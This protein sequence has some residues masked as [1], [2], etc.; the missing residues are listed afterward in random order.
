M[1]TAEPS[2]F[3]E[4]TSKCSDLVEF[5][6]VPGITPRDVVARTTD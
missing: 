2:L 5:E 4:L 1:E 6:I 3:D